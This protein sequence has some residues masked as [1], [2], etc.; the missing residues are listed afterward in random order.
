MYRNT[1]E[2]GQNF[3]TGKTEYKW[4]TDIIIIAWVKIKLLNLVATGEKDI[5]NALLT[6]TFNT[7]ADRDEWLKLFNQVTVLMLALNKDCNC[8]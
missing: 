4:C 7:S 2:Y 1:L 8:N 6:L 3:Y 5:S